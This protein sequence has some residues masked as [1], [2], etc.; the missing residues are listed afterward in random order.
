[1]AGA[2]LW[3]MVC[4]D[5]AA[6]SGGCEFDP[7]GLNRAG[8]YARHLERSCAIEDRERLAIQASEVLGALAEGKGVELVGVVVQGDLDLDR[9]PLRA[10][11][12]LRAPSAL[13][14][15]VLKGVDSVRVVPGPF[16]LQDSFVR[17]RLATSDVNGRVVI[18]GPLSVTGTTFDQ[19]VDLSRSVFV[20]PVDFSGATLK[21]EGLFVQSR[22]G[23]PVRFAGTIFG[24]QCRFHR[25]RFEQSVTFQQA[26]FNGSAE[27]LEVLFES[28]VDFSG[29][30][31]G[32][33]VGFSGSRF[34]SR[35]ELSKSSFERE[36]YFLFTEFENPVSFHRATFKSVADFSDA[37]FRQP[38]AFSR[39]RFAQRPRFDRALFP[40]GEAAPLG[41]GPTYQ[42]LGI[43]L[44]LVIAAALLVAYL[45]RFK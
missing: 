37:K 25:S 1:L 43:T 29:V 20:S 10:T 5:H 11:S 23:Q 27:F 7:E 19:V 45:V 44:A 32:S 33:G 8:A 22:F 17:G 28:D 35:V 13:L 42:Q 26:Q 40:P 34:R 41:D 14:S 16:L 18:Q 15:E 9:L 6:W 12:Q 39:T 2:G 30:T 21:R 38:A 4:A 36:A 31:F 3:V 24:S